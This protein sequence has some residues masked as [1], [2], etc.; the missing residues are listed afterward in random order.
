M[1]VGVGRVGAERVAV[2]PLPAQLLA[3]VDDL[4]WRVQVV[5]EHRENAVAVDDGDRLVAKPDVFLEARAVIVV[6]ADE[7]ACFIVN[8]NAAAAGNGGAGGADALA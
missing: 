7:V 4:P 6:F 5:A 2:V 8:V 3:G 1:G